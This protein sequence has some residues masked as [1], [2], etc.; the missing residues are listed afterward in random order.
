[1]FW[2]IILLLLIL[3]LFSRKY[4]H[5]MRYVGTFLLA[6]AGLFL[7]V[8]MVR[9]PSDAFD[10]A[11]QGLKIWWEVVFP[12]LL[13]FFIGSEILMGLGVVNFMGVML[14]PLMRPLFNVPGVGSFVMAMGL[15]SGYPIGAILTRR[16]RKEELCNQVEA[17]RL[18]SFTNTAD[19]LFM[20]G[21]VAVGMFGDARLG[22]IIAIAHYI[23]AVLVG[24]CTRFYRPDAPRSAQLAPER[25]NILLRAFKELFRARRRDGRPLGQILGDAVKGSVNSLLM[26]G[27]FIILFS[28]I[29][30]IAT[31][32]GLVA[33]VSQSIVGLLGALGLAQ[34]LGD[35]V[36]SGL[37]ELTNGCAVASATVAPVMDRVVMASAI[38]A[39][40]GLSVHAQVAAVLND[41]DVRIAPYI[42]ARALHGVFAGVCTWLLWPRLGVT[43]LGTIS[44]PA[45]L[46][47]AP[48]ASW[49][50][51]WQRLAFMGGRTALLM[52]ALLVISLLYQTIQPLRRIVWRHR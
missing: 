4:K 11:L 23:A 40:S 26:V 36:I 38:I 39:W 30:R 10:A 50:F 2:T 41:T 21:A 43:A 52:L 17:E 47:T 29:M 37:F 42:F 14:E 1:M 31:I 46:Q 12:A 35:S 6:A 18:V 8:S 5:L 9:A 19:P 15:A 32:T 34:S 45:F 20:V 33:A 27:G 16:L 24:L 28:V 51:F 48:S 22:T 25:G 7:T 13:P 49:G 44:L 3:F